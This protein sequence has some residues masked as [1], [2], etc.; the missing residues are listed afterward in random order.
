MPNLPKF[1]LDWDTKPPR[2]YERIVNVLIRVKGINREL[3]WLTTTN[4]AMKRI[5]RLVD[6][7]TARSFKLKIIGLGKTKDIN[8]FNLSKFRAKK[9]KGSSVL[10]VVERAKYSIDTRG[11][12]RGLSISKA[13]KKQ[14]SMVTKKKM[15]VKRGIVKSRNIKRTV[16]TKTKKKTSKKKSKSSKKKVRKK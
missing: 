5:T 11:E 9:S 6:N 13:L 7:T 15:V 2:G 8:K 14:K 16:K 10:D 1:K 3:K 4:R 12:K